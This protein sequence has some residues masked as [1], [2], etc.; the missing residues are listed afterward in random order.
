MDDKTIKEIDK[1]WDK[2]GLGDFIPSPS[3]KMKS[4]VKNEGAVAYTV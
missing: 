4:M 2:L 3:L 1:K